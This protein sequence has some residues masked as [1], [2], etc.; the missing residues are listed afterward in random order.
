MEEQ[1]PLMASRVHVV[2]NK[3]ELEMIGGKQPQQTKTTTSTP[4]LKQTN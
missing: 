3:K 1:P 4:A 2:R